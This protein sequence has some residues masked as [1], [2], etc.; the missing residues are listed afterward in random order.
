MTVR[1]L[2]RW[3]TASFR[4]WRRGDGGTRSG[5]LLLEVGVGTLAVTGAFDLDDGCMMQQAIEQGHCY[6]WMPEQRAA[7]IY[8]LIQTAKLNDVDHCK[9][10]DD[11]I[12]PDRDCATGRLSRSMT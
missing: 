2:L 4:R 1:S 12:V 3:P 8:T 10:A 11:F 9:R 5:V 7:I 6:H